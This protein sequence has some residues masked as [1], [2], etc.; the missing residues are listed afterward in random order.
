MHV[1]AAPD[2]GDELAGQFTAAGCAAPRDRA[3]LLDGLDP[4]QAELGLLPWRVLRPAV[5]N[6]LNDSTLRAAEHAAARSDIE[7]CSL[8]LAAQAV[9]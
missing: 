2:V 1:P 6:Y 7:L 9:V 5:A 4:A 8:V 3:F